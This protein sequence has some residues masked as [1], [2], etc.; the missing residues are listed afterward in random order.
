MDDSS[1]G[2]FNLVEDDRFP[3]YD[4]DQ[5]QPTG[6][7]AAIEL[8]EADRC[9]VLWELL[10]GQPNA[11][12]E[13]ADDWHLTDDV[14]QWLREYDHY[15]ERTGQPI[16]SGR[17]ID[18]TK[19]SPVLH[20]EVR[21]SAK[22]NQFSIRVLEKRFRPYPMVGFSNGCLTVDEKWPS[23]A[24]RGIGRIGAMVTESMGYKDDRRAIVRSRPAFS[25]SGRE[26]H[27]ASQH[28][29]P[30]D[31]PVETPVVT[32]PISPTFTSVTTLSHSV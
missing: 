1:N 14:A 16:T 2:G 4:R 10:M 8:A 21:S 24:Y 7:G 17:V 6:E 5:A 31:A 19:I 28:A 18:L 23:V 9:N 29:T 13:K 32:P 30:V 20:F 3:A 27:A 26:S 25:E 11:H 12:E 15:V 22:L